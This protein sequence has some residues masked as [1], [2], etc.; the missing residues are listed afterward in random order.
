MNT[1][2]PI[3]L[4]TFWHKVTQDSFYMTSKWSR[5][6]E[7]QN[8]LAWS[9]VRNQQPDSPTLSSFFLN[10]CIGSSLLVLRTLNPLLIV[11]ILSTYPTTL[12]PL[13]CH[14]RASNL[15]RHTALQMLR[16]LFSI[17]K[18][19]FLLALLWGVFFIRF[20]RALG[21]GFS[22]ELVPL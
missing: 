20:N 22:I 8:R 13:D 18:V 4:K 12:N 1:N 11:S 10:I 15:T 9:S 14:K 17:W 7:I 2:S 3:L 19:R 16:P 21:L 5:Q 6:A